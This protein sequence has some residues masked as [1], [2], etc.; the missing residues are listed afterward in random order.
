MIKAQIFIAG[1]SLI[2]FI[3]TIVLIK[4]RVLREEYAI[5]WIIS[6]AALFILG[7]LPGSLSLISAAM[8]VYY[9]SAIFIIAFLFLLLVAFYS[10]IVLSRLSDANR[11]LSQEV[12]LLKEKIEKQK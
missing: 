7:I 1:I 6:E 2:L 3:V 4:R 12:A 5:I 11:A 9:L 10:S 8:G